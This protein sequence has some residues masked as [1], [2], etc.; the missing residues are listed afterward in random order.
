M[1]LQ[2]HLLSFEGPDRYAFAGGI[3]SR[4]SGLAEALAALGFETHLWFVGDPFLPGHEHRGRLH[5]HR[6][7]QWMSRHNPAGV[8]DGQEGKVAEYATSLPP[9][10]AGEIAGWLS[11]N[12]AAVVLAEEWHTAP[13]V[14]HLD[15]LLRSRGV[16]ERV[17]IFWNANNTFG[18][19][20][21]DWRGLASASIV[22]TVSRYMKHL[23]GGFGVQ[24]LVIP[25]G[26]SPDAFGA[27]P[28]GDVSELN[29]R[30]EGRTLI[31]KV[32]RF[33]PDKRWLSAVEIV[34]QLKRKGARPL[35]IARGGLEA[36]GKEVLQAVKRAGLRIG[37]R[38]I[39]EP[40]TAGLFAALEESD[41]LDVLHFCSHLDW[42]SR[43]LLYRESDAV[44][45]NSGHEPFGLVGLET[46]AVGGVA[47]TGCSG[48]DYAVPG[49]NAL[50]M[51][52]ENPGEFMA[53]FRRL[54]AV[55]DEEQAIREA[56]L[57]TARQYAWPGVIRRS[58]LPRVAMDLGEDREL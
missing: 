43:R 40:G 8:Y 38:L 13:A 15:Q 29:Q 18:F 17:S 50:V 41:D 33:D 22:T 52:T 42:E 44:L 12:S 4:V 32:A 10:L 9:L 31:T 46:M 5:L 25:N 23:M 56:G 45:A 35:F 2:F 20:G 28:A 14:V 11:S 51:Q 7:C 37:E 6:W 26:L 53:L 19:E 1:S 58:L 3:A 34:A 57:A 39:K 36:H 21:I 16:R 27:V 24:A 48:E 47:C 54:R 30:V 49:H 55:P